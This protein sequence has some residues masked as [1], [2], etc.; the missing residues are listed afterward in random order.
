MIKRL[1][2]LCLI[3]M[4][5][6]SIFA[7]HTDSLWQKAESAY[8]NKDFKEAQVLYDSILNQSKYSKALYFNLGNTYFKQNQLG[9][10]ILYYEKAKKLAPND[11]DIVHNL[12][13]CQRLI[14]DELSE[15]KMSPVQEALF[16]NDDPKRYALWF[17]GAMT[18]LFLGGL[19]YILKPYNKKVL[20]SII[21]ITLVVGLGFAA[22]SYKH[23]K[24]QKTKTHGIITDLI[25][26]AKTQPNNDAPTTFI[27]HEGSK[28]EIVTSLEEWTKILFDSDKIGWIQT[29]HLETI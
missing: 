14:T 20:Y 15:Y 3:L 28:I 21:S 5:S 10:A 12:T 24:F 11:E 27:L 16:M 1:T 26:H 2:Y 4:L 29:K 7:Q 19:I 25:A 6:S 9:K 22:L 23:Q 13:F 18:V 17:V 8:Q